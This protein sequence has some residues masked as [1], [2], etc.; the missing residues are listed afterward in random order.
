MRQSAASVPRSWLSSV[1]QSGLGA[2]GTMDVMG[3]AGTSPGLLVQ[4]CLPGDSR[5]RE[6]VE[7][8]AD[9]PRRTLR[10]QHGPRRG[11]GAWGLWSWPAPLRPRRTLRRDLRL[12][13]SVL[14]SNPAPLVP[15][16]HLTR[17]VRATPTTTS[18]RLTPTTRVHQTEHT[19]PGLTNGSPLKVPAASQ[20]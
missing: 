13:R 14:Q 11:C 20:L 9:A 10:C 2:S 1:L 18:R 15:R 3:V 4:P 8:T 7:L 19:S 16:L 5:Y 17:R 6:W 12:D